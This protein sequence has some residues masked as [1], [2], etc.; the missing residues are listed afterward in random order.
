MQIANAK[1]AVKNAKKEK[2]KDKGKD[3]D[4]LFGEDM[5]EFV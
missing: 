2:N 4:E 1:R 3:Q 5:D